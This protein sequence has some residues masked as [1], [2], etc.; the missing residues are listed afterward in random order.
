MY[1]MVVDGVKPYDGRYEIDFEFTTQELGWIKRHAGYLPAEI[2]DAFRGID[3]ELLCVFAVIGMRRAGKVDKRDVADVFERLSEAKFGSMSFEA[4][5]EEEDG[6]VS[7]PPQRSSSGP[8]GT[9]GPGSTT[10]SETSEDAQ[11]FSG[12][13]GSGSAESAQERLAG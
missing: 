2:E 8:T 10:S 4:D 5:P 13:P 11:S 7:S 9:S 12:M 6:V 1:W 3:A